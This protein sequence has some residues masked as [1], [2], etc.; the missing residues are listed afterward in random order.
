MFYSRFHQLFR[1]PTFEVNYKQLP[2]I[3]KKKI[4][5]IMF[6]QLK[7]KNILKDLLIDYKL[8]TKFDF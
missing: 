8:Y 6:K 7:N 3:L 2:Q 1:E 5:F 4:K